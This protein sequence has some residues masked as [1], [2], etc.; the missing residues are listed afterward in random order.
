MTS[1]TTTAARGGAFTVGVQVLRMVLQ[2]GSVVVLARLLAP[3][4]F[5]LVAMVTALMGLAELVRDFGL[6]VAATQA[7]TVSTAERDNLFWVNTG[8]GAAVAVALTAAVP[9]LVRLYD[10]PRLVPIVPS[11]AVVLLL[12]GMVT[13]YRA[14]LARRLRFGALATA[15][16]ASPAAGIAVAVVLAA[17][18]AGVW[19]LVAQQVT[20]AA[21]MLAVCVGHG[22]WLPGRYRR[23]IPIRRFHRF[24]LALL[25]TQA[26]GYA[27]RNIDQ[28]AIGA[29]RGP[30]ELGLYNRAYQLVMVPLNQI[31]APLTQVAVPVLS[32]V[33]DDTTAFARGLR[34]AQLVTSYGTATLLVV[35]A[36]LADPLTAVLLGPGWSA[37]APV[38][39]VL[40]LA[41]AFRS[42]AQIAY[43]MYLASGRAGQL[44]HLNLWTQPLM[45]A[46]V[47]AGLPWGGVGVATGNLVANVLYWLVSLAA[48]ARAVGVAA[49][50]LLASAVTA[51][52]TA[53]LPAGL[54]ALA[55]ASSVDGPWLRLVLGLGAAVAGATLVTGLVPRSRHDVLTVLGLVRSV[56]GR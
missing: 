27:T 37:V 20:A 24:G 50:P 5:G 1:L 9:L 2:V 32:R 43:W 52:L 8:L 44:L 11:L 42:L 13:Q 10:E 31:N 56:L 30:V 29:I 33:L 55:V 34:R 18:G 22:R 25:G 14:D 23:D 39:A 38:L 40:A 21:V 12:S 41:G 28:V 3:E 53:A 36:A 54:A 16:L 46:L 7:R 47:L 19:A 45:M 35:V 4:V 6:S 15:D 48:A 26:L 51:S 49:R 17:N